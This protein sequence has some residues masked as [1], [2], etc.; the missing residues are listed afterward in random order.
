M[1]EIRLSSKLED[2]LVFP[3]ENKSL[4]TYKNWGFY[5]QNTRV[6]P[7]LRS[8]RDCHYFVPACYLNAYMTDTTDH[9]R[10]HRENSNPA[11][12]YKYESR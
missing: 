10:I 9:P 2:S 12:L 8:I 11:Q 4:K 5:D 7:C 3:Q 1:D 6:V